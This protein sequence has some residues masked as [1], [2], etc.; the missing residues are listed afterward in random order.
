[1]VYKFQLS[2]IM[3]RRRTSGLSA[4]LTFLTLGVRTRRGD[5]KRLGPGISLALSSS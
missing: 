3:L 5:I 4:D 1:M 2:A